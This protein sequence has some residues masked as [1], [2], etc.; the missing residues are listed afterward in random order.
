MCRGF[1]RSR[2]S[3][4]SSAEGTLAPAFDPDDRAQDSKSPGVRLSIMAMPSSCVRRRTVLRIIARDRLRSKAEWERRSDQHLIMPV[5]NEQRSAGLRLD[6]LIDALAP[7][8]SGAD[9]KKDSTTCRIFVARSPSRSARHGTRVQLAV[10][11]GPGLPSG[12]QSVIHCFEEA[13]RFFGGCEA[14]SST[15]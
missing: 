9:S 4:Y 12:L 13:F 5:T 8:R 1:Q 10:L 14:L 11:R 7:A 6:D 2:Q 15:A 3:S